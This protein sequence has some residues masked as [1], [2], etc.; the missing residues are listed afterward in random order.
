MARF[1]VVPRGMEDIVDYIKERY[2]NMPMFVT[3]NGMQLPQS[4]FHLL[5]FVCGIEGD[6]KSISG[7]SS[8]VV[9]DGSF[10][11]DVGRIQFH[12]SYLAYLARAIR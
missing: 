7:Y 8:P 11:H 6:P 4:Y 9:E 2:N 5:N 10:Q 3:E 12:Q 1:Y